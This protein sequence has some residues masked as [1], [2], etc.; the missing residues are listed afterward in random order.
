M[1]HSEFAT[2]L[3]E[4]ISNSIEAAKPQRTTEE[5]IALLFKQLDVFKDVHTFE[6]GH[7]VRVKKGFD[8]FSY[9]R[10]GEPAIVIE[11]LRD[12]KPDLSDSTAPTYGMINDLRLGFFTD[13]GHFCIMG[14]DSRSFEPWPA[15]EPVTE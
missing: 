5:K 4:H 2:A 12:V 7:I 13:K 11:V 1:S 6:Q 9:P 14:F 15:S 8:Y 10:K 3:L